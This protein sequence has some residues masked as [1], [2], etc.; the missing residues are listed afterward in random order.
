MYEVIARSEATKQS[1]LI[2]S[3]KTD[4]AEMIASPPMADRNDSDSSFSRIF[5]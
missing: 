3:I 1:F 5:K 2:A 4:L